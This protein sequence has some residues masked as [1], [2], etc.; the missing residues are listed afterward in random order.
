MTLQGKEEKT[1]T[2]KEKELE[3]ER[4][5]QLLYYSHIDP[6]FA[7]KE[8]R[9]D[10]EKIRDP[11]TIGVG[12]LLRLVLNDGDKYIVKDGKATES[13]PATILPIVY[14]CSYNT[15]ENEDDLIQA[16]KKDKEEKD[17]TAKDVAYFYQTILDTYRGDYQLFIKKDYLRHEEKREILRLALDNGALEEIK[18]NITLDLL[19][20]AYEKREPTLRE[21][22]RW[23]ALH[24]TY[25]RHFLLMRFTLGDLIRIYKALCDLHI[26]LPETTQSSEAT[27]EEL[28]RIA[29]IKEYRTRDRAGEVDAIPHSD[30]LSLITYPAYDGALSLAR[31]PFK[32]AGLA[33]IQEDTKW[34]ILEGRWMKN[35]EETEEILADEITNKRGEAID[36]YKDTD[37][38]LLQEFYSIFFR[39]FR[40]ENENRDPSEYEGK[41]IHNFFVPE[42]LREISGSYNIKGGY[43]DEIIK[44]INSFAGIAGVF[45]KETRP[46]KKRQY[47]KILPLLI[48]HKYD[49]DTNLLQ[50][51][52][53]YFNYLLQELYD[54]SIKRDK[55]GLPKKKKDG[56][57]LLEATHSELVRKSITKERNK[58]AVVNVFLL[59]AQVEQAGSPSSKEREEGISRVV[60]RKV[61]TL[62]DENPELEK[63]LEEAKDTRSKNKILNRTFEKTYELLEKETLLSDRYENFTLKEAPIPTIQTLDE[64]TIEIVH[65]GKKLH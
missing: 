8:T 65:D 59:V 7:Y 11:N 58:R 9:E 5:R 35:G 20:Y 12:A 52:S 51:S 48:L 36:V 38:P 25:R 24:Y 33:P 30:F 45:W 23:E 43:I 62:I 22:E 3:E 26:D 31:L 19:T 47:R 61:K 14:Y 34:D 53:P 63:A 39:R 41:E 1:M 10:R 50:L 27:L 29:P 40:D 49:A 15:I 4:Q 60:R 2:D 21:R 18:D 56:S 37:F 16:M 28:N 44:K 13:S 46:G 32:K 57:P 42:L 54:A 64:C 17:E 55:Q 6:T